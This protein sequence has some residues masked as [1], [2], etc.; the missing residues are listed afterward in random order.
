MVSVYLLSLLF[1]VYVLSDRDRRA[2]LFLVFSTRS[3]GRYRN[4]QRKQTTPKRGKL[5][6]KKLPNR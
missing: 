3:G 5:E 6:Q 1:A 4:T 2:K